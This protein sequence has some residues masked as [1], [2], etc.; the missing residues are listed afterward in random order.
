MRG[1][2]EGERERAWGSTTWVLWHRLVG[3]GGKN[4][5]E[6]VRGY[7][8]MTRGTSGSLRWLIGVHYGST[9][10]YSSKIST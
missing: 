3:M 4:A 5:V 8:S 6:L 1:E 10:V 2:G 9:A 7:V